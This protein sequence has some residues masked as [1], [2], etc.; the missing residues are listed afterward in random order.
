[1]RTEKNTIKKPNQMEME[2]NRNKHIDLTYLKELSNGSN[3]FIV[4]MIDGFLSETPPA[5]DKLEKHLSTSNWDEFRAIAH[6]IKPSF[7]FVGIKEL[8]EVIKS[9]EEYSRTRTNLGLLPE[10]VSK[11]KTI[12][13]EASQELKIAKNEYL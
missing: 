10:I 2:T 12:T 7:S 11:V 6:K 13:E 9:A 1:M 4:E 5:I 3:S 8:E